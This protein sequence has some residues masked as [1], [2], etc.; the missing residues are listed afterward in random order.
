MPRHFR[1]TGLAI[2]RIP[3]LSRRG[4]ID[5]VRS[6][7]AGDTGVNALR[8]PGTVGP[9]RPVKARIARGAASVPFI[10]TTRQPRRSRRFTRPTRPR[11]AR[12]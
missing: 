5:K 9:Q 7:R 11:R 12:R 8:F 2:F 10:N 4:R 6:R 3:A 1:P